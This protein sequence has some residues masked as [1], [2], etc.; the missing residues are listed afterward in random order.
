MAMAVIDRDARRVRRALGG[1]S[2]AFTELV[3]RHMPAVRAVARACTGNLADAE[4]VVQEAFLKA[5]LSLDTLQE[6]G[7]F[8]GWVVTIARNVARSQLR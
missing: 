8:G 5:W 2:A 6:P 4:D 7:R 3:T 1:D